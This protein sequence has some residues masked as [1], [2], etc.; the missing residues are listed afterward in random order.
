M[1]LV[2]LDLG[3]ET[4]QMG[5]ELVLLL[6]QTAPIGVGQDDQVEALFLFDLDSLAQG[7]M[8]LEGGFAELGID[9][10]TGQPFEQ[11]ATLGVG[12]F[13]EFGELAL[14]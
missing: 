14:G 7:F 6:F 2:L 1:A 13:E 10:G 4:G 3:F 8:V 9:L 5:L 11:L 12:G